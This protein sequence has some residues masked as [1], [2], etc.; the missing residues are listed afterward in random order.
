[1]ITLSFPRIRKITV[2]LGVLGAIIAWIAAGPSA[3]GA[4][5]TGAAISLASLHSWIRLAEL[6]DPNA[7]TRPGRG[8]AAFLALRY[9]LIGVT[10]Y[11]IIKYLRFNPAALIVGMLVSFGA[12]LVDLLFGLMLPGNKQ[13]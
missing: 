3:A 2:I 9:V 7:P 12:V 6:L 11:V 1:M 10:L 5:L 4:F 8:S 13:S